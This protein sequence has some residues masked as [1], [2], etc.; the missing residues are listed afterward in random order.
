M[1]ELSFRGLHKDKQ[2]SQ[3]LSCKHTCNF[4]TE[5]VTSREKEVFRYLKAG[6]PEHSQS[7]AHFI[8]HDLLWKTTLCTQ[9]SCS[10]FAIPGQGFVHTLGPVEVTIRYIKHVIVVE[11]DICSRFSDRLPIRHVRCSP[12]SVTPSTYDGSSPLKHKL[13]RAMGGD[14]W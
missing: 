3:G 10:D 1:T 12:R 14:L 7:G 6:T 11:L 4:F 9:T 8:L 13:S 5:V 2:P